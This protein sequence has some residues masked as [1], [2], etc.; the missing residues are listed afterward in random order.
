VN[1]R[2]DLSFPVFINIDG[3]DSTVTGNADE[4]YD[5]F[6][7]PPA[8]AGL[9]SLHAAGVNPN[10]SFTTKS[11][12]SKINLQATVTPATL[13][14]SI[15]WFAADDPSDHVQTAAPATIPDGSPSS[16]NVPAAQPIAR[17]SAYSHPGNLD[18]KSLSLRVRAQVTDN[19]GVTVFGSDTVTVRQ[20]EID[21]IREEYIELNISHGVPSRDKFSLVPI[22]TFQNCGDFN[23]AFIDP[24]FVSAIN[25]LQVSFNRGPLTIN[26]IYRNPVHNKLHAS[27]NA[28]GG[29]SSV[30]DPNSWHQYGCA[31]DFQTFPTQPNTPAK[32]DAALAYHS[33]LSGIARSLHFH[34][35]EL[36][37]KNGHLG[38]GVGHVHVHE[39]PQ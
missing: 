4:E 38:S 36:V 6:F 17:Y 26:V 27:T 15:K 33:D 20:D 7:G 30:V 1:A 12:E 31:A 25:Q 14:A 21:T 37:P 8:G 9:T 23:Y 28:C 16:F 13:A 22:N 11:S 35:E 2:Q 18:Q 32:L 39:C 24:A 29:K 3:K 34:V 5:L 10:G 19:A